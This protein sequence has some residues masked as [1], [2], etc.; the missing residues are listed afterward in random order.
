MLPP[1]APPPDREPMVSS[2]PSK[3]NT[4]PVASANEIGVESLSLSLAPSVNEPAEIVN[5]LN[6]LNVPSR[7]N[8]CD[9]TL[10][11]EPKV[12]VTSLDSFNTCDDRSVP[13]NVVGVLSLPAVNVIPGAT[14]TRPAP[15]IEAMVSAA[16]TSYTPLVP[17]LTAVLSDKVPVTLTEP[18]E[19][20]VA[21][22]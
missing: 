9:P 12:V 3:S 7:V 13:L 10:V 11:N 14:S 20:V 15:A 21:P 6:W 22:V 1:L 8:A 2:L 17:T 19:I 18:A 4:A 16:S 5:W